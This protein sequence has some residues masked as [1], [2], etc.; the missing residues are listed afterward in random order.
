MNTATRRLMV[1]AFTAFAATG[2]DTQSDVLTSSTQGRLLKADGTWTDW[3]AQGDSLNVS[4]DMATFMAEAQQGSV[5]TEQDETTACGLNLDASGCSW[6]IRNCVGGHVQAITTA[7]IGCP[8][9]QTATTTASWSDCA[10]A[11]ANGS[12]GDACSWQSAC[13]QA[14]DDPCCIE[15]AICADLG[16]KTVVQR[17]RICAPDCTGIAADTSQPQVSTCADAAAAIDHYAV[18]CAASLACSQTGQATFV[19]ITA[20]D[21]ATASGSPL[22]FCADGKVV[23]APNP[24]TTLVY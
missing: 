16:V 5:C 13:S 6:N 17:N 21:N 22:Y 3:C 11:L 19:D 2:C 15:V 4:F 10:S 1:L 14:T 23:F 8:V 24:L 7:T 18:P 12:S 9:S 20:A